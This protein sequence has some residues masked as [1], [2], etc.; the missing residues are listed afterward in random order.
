MGGTICLALSGLN[1]TESFVP[2]FHPGLCYPA[3]SGLFMFFIRIWFV[4]RKPIPENPALQGMRIKLRE[5]I[6]SAES[7][8]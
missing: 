6:P 1:V 2:G 7:A 5:N 8:A 3:L 4:S